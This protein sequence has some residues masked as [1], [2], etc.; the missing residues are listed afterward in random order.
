MKTLKIEYYREE[1]QIDSDSPDHVEIDSYNVGEKSL[2]PHLRPETIRMIEDD[3]L[4]F[5]RM[6]ENEI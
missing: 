5:E 4:Q 3:L 6:K 2:W 1:P